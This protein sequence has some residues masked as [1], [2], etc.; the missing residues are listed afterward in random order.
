M[1]VDEAIAALA[2][3]RE[4][5]FDDPEL[6]RRVEAARQAAASRRPD[7]GLEGVVVDA[8]P[9]LR[10]HQEEL[11]A[12]N[13][14]LA[15]LFKRGLRLALVDLR[16]VCALQQAV[17]TD[18]EFP[19]IDVGDVRALAEWTLRQAG[20]PL[21]DVHYNGRRRAWTISVQD[22][23]IRIVKHIRTE[24][25]H[26]VGL[27]FEIRQFGSSLQAVRFRDR[28][29]LVDGYHRAFALLSR[30]VNLVP[31]LVGGT[32]SAEELRELAAGLGLDVVLGPRPPM[33]PDFLD[34]EVA[35]EVETPEGPRVLVVEAMDIRTAG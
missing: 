3:R 11:A 8:P 24:L 16:R 5:Q 9:E 29:L 17:Y 14:R 1:R 13:P 23:N 28:F 21:L 19:D 2:G 15:G 31:G 12:I 10:A 26:G 25:E 30:G 27:G 4:E 20:N 18:G 7:V 35:A 22:P 6:A 34:D 32:D 33:L